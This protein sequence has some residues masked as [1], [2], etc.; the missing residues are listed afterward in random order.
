MQVHMSREGESEAHP[1]PLWWKAAFPAV[2]PEN[3]TWLKTRRS[4]H[5]KE[6]VNKILLPED[7]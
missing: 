1:A 6:P 4:Q 3:N 5:S 2:L 7:K